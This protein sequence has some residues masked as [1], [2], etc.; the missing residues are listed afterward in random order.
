[1]FLIMQ[2]GKSTSLCLNDLNNID[3]LQ[4]VFDIRNITDAEELAFFLQKRL[5]HVSFT[6]QY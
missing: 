5:P 2:T 6:D 1:M 3:Y 4:R